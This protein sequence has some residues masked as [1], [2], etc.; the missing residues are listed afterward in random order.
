MESLPSNEVSRVKF[1]FVSSYSSVVYTVEVIDN[2]KTGILMTC[3]H[4]SDNHDSPF[5]SK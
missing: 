1:F 2:A 5:N 4:Q 3:G